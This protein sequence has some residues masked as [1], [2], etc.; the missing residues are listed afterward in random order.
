M[1]GKPEDILAFITKIHDVVDIFDAEVVVTVGAAKFIVV[2]L[3]T[4]PYEV[5]VS[6]VAYAAT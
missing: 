3:L 6:L 4:E 2:K 5:P 1:L